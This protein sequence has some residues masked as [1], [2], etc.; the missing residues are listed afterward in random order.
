M[1]TLGTEY[2]TTFSFII[3]RYKSP[4]P[5]R[6][7]VTQAKETEEVLLRLQCRRYKSGSP[8]ERFTHSDHYLPQGDSSFVSC[9]TSVFKK[10][11]FV[12]FCWKQK[13]LHLYPTGICI[14][15]HTG[16]TRKRG[17]WWRRSNQ[18]VAWHLLSWDEWNMDPRHEWL[19]DDVWTFEA[20]R[21][22]VL[23]WKKLL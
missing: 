5:T 10:G 2:S 17:E 20:A 1:H 14:H 16:M 12:I 22:F 4:S 21:T 6:D 8:H 23:I 11:Q 19:L 9:W 13:Y 18:D 7:A 3:E 15:L